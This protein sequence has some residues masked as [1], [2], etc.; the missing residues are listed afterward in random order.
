M[1][2]RICFTI[3]EFC[4]TV[5]ISRSCYYALPVADRPKET[6]VGPK[7]IVITRAA[8]MEWLST[9]EGRNKNNLEQS[10]QDG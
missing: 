9:R 7:R 5:R 4:E 2:E 1:N 3:K 10:N 8:V 6:R